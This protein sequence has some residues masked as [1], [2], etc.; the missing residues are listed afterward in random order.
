M[1]EQSCILWKENR[2]ESKAI[3]S[4]LMLSCYLK[5]SNLVT[6]TLLSS[7]NW[8]VLIRAGGERGRG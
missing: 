8:E 2:C 4:N 7:E 3:F 6:K 1:Y 5:M